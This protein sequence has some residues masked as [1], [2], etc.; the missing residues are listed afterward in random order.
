MRL[1][2]SQAQEQTPRVQRRIVSRSRLP[3]RRP[4]KS[5]MT[6][7]PG[8]SLTGKAGNRVQDVVNISIEGAFVAVTIGYSFIPASVAISAPAALQ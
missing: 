2:L 1:G 4:R 8:L 6:M 7:W 3:H 5:P